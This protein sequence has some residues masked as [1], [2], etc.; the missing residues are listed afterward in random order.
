MVLK[1]R[2][3]GAFL[4]FMTGWILNR[5][6][7]SFLLVA[8]LLPGM[9]AGCGSGASAIGS[10]LLFAAKAPFS[11]ASPPELNPSF[12][13][14]RVRHEGRDA[15]LARGYVERT[16]NGLREV[17]YSAERETLTLLDGRLVGFS[18]NDISLR[19]DHI[20]ATPMWSTLFG[21]MHRQAFAYARQFSRLPNGPLAVREEVQIIRLNPSA[22]RRDPTRAGELTW[23]REVFSPVTARSGESNLPYASDFAFVANALPGSTS[24]ADSAPVA[25]L[26]VYS[27]QC[28]SPIFCIEI[29]PWPPQ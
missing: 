15:Y 18:S 2:P 14:L 4:W 24:V 20:G 5:F 16:Q 22:V 1:P 17:Y 8:V 7:A 23:A 27:R 3:G 9:L 12:Q 19:V 29:E 6:R 25:T 26:P 28:L 11:S 13:Y 21:A 10:T